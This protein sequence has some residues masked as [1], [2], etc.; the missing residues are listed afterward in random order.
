[1]NAESAYKQFNYIF[2]KSYDKSFPIKS[3]FITIKDIHKPW[4]T[5]IL[6]G[7]IKK[8]DSLHKLVSKNK[9]SR[10]EYTNYRNE[11]TSELRKAKTK[12]FEDQFERNSNIKKH[13]KLSIMSLDQ[14]SIL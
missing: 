13:G 5:D 10:T 2:Q 6:I 4:V 11:L 12:Y 7:K 3:K 1:M 8:R 9:I 14:K